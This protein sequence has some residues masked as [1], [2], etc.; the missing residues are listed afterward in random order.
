MRRLSRSLGTGIAALDLSWRSE[1]DG[2]AIKGSDNYFSR[3]DDNSSQVQN[4][5]D[6]KSGWARSAFANPHS[7]S[8]TFL[9]ELPF[10][11]GK[12]L[13]SSG[14]VGKHLLGAGRLA[15]RPIITAGRRSACSRAST[16]PAA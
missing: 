2:L 16:T 15:G 9:Y 11:P 6:R 5:Y 10:G 4:L 1:P 8:V 13:L 3:M 7:V 14:F 12:P